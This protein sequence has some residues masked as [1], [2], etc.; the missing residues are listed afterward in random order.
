MNLFRNCSRFFFLQISSIVFS[1][2]ISIKKYLYGFLQ[3]IL[4]RISKVFQEIF[5]KFVQKYLGK[6]SFEI[7]PKFLQKIPQNSFT[8]AFKFFQGF[9]LKI[10]KGIALNIPLDN[11]SSIFFG[12]KP[13]FFFRNSFTDFFWNFPGIPAVKSAV[14][15]LKTIALTSFLSG[16]QFIYQ[17]EEI[18][19]N[20]LLVRDYINDWDSPRRDGKSRN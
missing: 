14:Q 20:L 9:I 10:S 4:Q 3:K 15:L 17:I 12:R 1:L 18:N 6:L 16:S 11:S 2:F 13:D 8:D 5:L 7:S 19:F